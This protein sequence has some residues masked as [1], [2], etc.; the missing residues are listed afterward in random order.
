[1]FPGKRS[2]EALM[3]M[4]ERPVGLVV[5]SAGAPEQLPGLPAVGMQW[6]GLSLVPVFFISAFLVFALSPN[7]LSLGGVMLVTVVLLALIY[8][9]GSSRPAIPMGKNLWELQDQMEEQGRR[10]VE[11]KAGRAMEFWVGDLAFP[12][13]NTE[14]APTGLGWD[15]ERL[16]VLSEGRLASFPP[17]LVRSWKSYVDP[18]VPNVPFT[19]RGPVDKMYAQAQ[20]A[21]Q[22][23]RQELYARRRSGL[24]VYV[25]DINRP[26][27]R[28]ETTD[29]T[30]LAQ[31]AELLAQVAGQGGESGQG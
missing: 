3:D 16:H 6:V 4:Q 28:I 15:G 14:G 20:A 30:K 13:S 2:G 29:T 26:E 17:S 1:M 19:W 11:E 25:R 7:G 27:W 8:A 24:F 31:M 5:E 22:A 10:A 21:A 18:H 12:P 23:L 9:F